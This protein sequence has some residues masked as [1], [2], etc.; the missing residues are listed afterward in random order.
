[1]SEFRPL[2]EPELDAFY[3]GGCPFCGC[4]TCIPGPSGGMSTNIQCPKCEARLNV[5]LGARFPWGQVLQE[6]NEPWRSNPNPV[7]AYMAK[8]MF[9][10][11]V[12]MLLG[13]R[14]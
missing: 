5:V 10:Q 11:L 6:P 12:D 8:G 3:R 1:M 2:T 14:V 13:R 4:D 7:P 9:G